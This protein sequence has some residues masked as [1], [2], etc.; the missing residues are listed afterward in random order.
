[1]AAL[2]GHRDGR[3]GRR[4]RRAGDG[5]TVRPVSTGGSSSH[6][7]D[8]RE[9][10]IELVPLDSEPTALAA[11]LLRRLRTDALELACEQFAVLDDG[12]IR[13]QKRD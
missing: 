12:A 10:N 6:G 4:R 13:Q 9:E 5:K 7:P 2:R 3:S 11:A 1:M 8:H